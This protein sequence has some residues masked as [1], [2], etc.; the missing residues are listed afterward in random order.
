MFGKTALQI[1]GVLAVLATI[2]GVSFTAPVLAT[3]SSASNSLTITD[4]DSVDQTNVQSSTQNAEINSNNDLNADASNDADVSAT[5]SGDG[6]N[7]AVV[8][9]D[10][11][12]E[13]T[14]VVANVQVQG[15]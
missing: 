13:Q 4:N 2:G 3:D 1:L 6:D 12:N 10:Q 14:E 11:S 15:S 7:L 8:G 9:E 5:E